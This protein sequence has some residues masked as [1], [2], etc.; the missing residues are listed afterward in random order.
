MLIVKMKGWG[1]SL[2]K[3]IGTSQGAAIWEFN[4]TASSYWNAELRQPYRY[5]RIMPAEPKS[6]QEVEVILLQSPS[7]PEETWVKKGQGVALIEE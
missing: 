7:A 5:A 2:D 4:R 3:K 1:L 6:G